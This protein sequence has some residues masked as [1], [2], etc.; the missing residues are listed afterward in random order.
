MKPEDERIHDTFMLYIM[1]LAFLTASRV[2]IM[3][4]GTGVL[5]WIQMVYG[6]TLGYENNTTRPMIHL[7][8]PEF[9]CVFFPMAPRL[10]DR[11]H[12]VLHGLDFYN[13]VRPFTRWRTTFWVI[14]LGHSSIL[15]LGWSTSFFFSFF[16][17]PCVLYSW[18]KQYPSR[19]IV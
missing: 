2:R 4:P 8:S 19:R 12:H 1:R 14:S 18:E 16:F 11:L 10:L 13:H 6:N 5:E 7:S 15:L 17:L 9:M 3:T